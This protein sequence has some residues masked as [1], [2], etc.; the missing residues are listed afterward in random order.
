MVREP[1]DG[2]EVVGAGPATVGISQERRDDR[3][4]LAPGPRLLLLGP[5][6]RRCPLAAR[7]RP[8]QGAVGRA[9]G[10]FAM[11][12]LRVDGKGPFPCGRLGRDGP[13]QSTKAACL[14]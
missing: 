11:A 14:S 10:G 5:N 12:Q 2:N 8:I 3:S 9:L 6:D 4:F 13:S 1:W 7:R